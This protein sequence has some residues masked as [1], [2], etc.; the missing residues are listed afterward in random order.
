M[1]INKEETMAQ[2]L[3]K[4]F[5]IPQDR[6]NFFSGSSIHGQKVVNALKYKKR[7]VSQASGVKLNSIRYDMK[8]PVELKERLIEWATA[9]NLVASFFKDND[10]TILWFYTPNPLLG[11]VTPRN[12]IRVGRCQKLITFIRNALLE[13]KPE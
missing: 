13:N 1:T 7:E 9:I 12:M 4:A 11:E 6:F 10:K 5:A 3:N 2:Q 8:M